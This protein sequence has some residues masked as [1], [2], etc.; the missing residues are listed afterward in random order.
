MH[1]DVLCI[2]NTS[3]PYNINRIDVDYWFKQFGS[4]SVQ[5][6]GSN[7]F[8]SNARHIEDIYICICVETYDIMVAQGSA[9]IMSW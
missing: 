8:G 2:Y 6:D 7:I 5:L 1:V 9:H 3:T 4:R